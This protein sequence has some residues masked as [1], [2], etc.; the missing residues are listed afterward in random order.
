MKT[1]FNIC[2]IGTFSVLQELYGSRLT[3]L[4]GAK[5]AAFTIPV[6]FLAYLS[7]ALKLVDVSISSQISYGCNPCL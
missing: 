2:L 3:P 5:L 6:K 1:I 4:S 7:Q